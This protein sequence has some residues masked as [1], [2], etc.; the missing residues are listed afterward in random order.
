MAAAIEKYHITAD[1]I[2]NFDEKGFLIG[3]T[4][5][6]KRIIS[7]EVFESSRVTKTRQ[8]GNR[9]FISCL[10]CVSAVGKAIP[11]VL[12]YTGKSGDLQTTWMEEVTDES[13]VHFSISTNGWSND[14]I[15]LL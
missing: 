1:N 10:A 3:F 2:Y 13:G 8:D 5:A 11:P 14:E 9:E 6:L 15:G 12:I 7:R 4:K